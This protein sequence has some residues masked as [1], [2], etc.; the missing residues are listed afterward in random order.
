M[1][2][3]PARNNNSS[4]DIVE[5]REARVEVAE[6]EG[7]LNLK[8]LKEKKISEHSPLLVARRHQTDLYTELPPQHARSNPHAPF[9]VHSLASP[10]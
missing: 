10:C 9:E 8:A 2:R 1:G 7:G 4:N 5:I 3:M 6:E